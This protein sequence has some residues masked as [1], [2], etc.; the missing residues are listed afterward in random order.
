MFQ[1]KDGSNGVAVG[2][3]ALDRLVGQYSVG[4]GGNAGRNATGSYN[5]FVGFF[6]WKKASL[7]VTGSV[8]TI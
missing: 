6:C 3:F 4:I 7:V 1:V 5:T 8:N 2:S